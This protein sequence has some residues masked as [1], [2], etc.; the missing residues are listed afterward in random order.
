MYKIDKEINKREQSELWSEDMAK[1][2]IFERSRR[3]KKK[4]TVASSMF[5][6]LFLFF[7]ISFNVSL[8]EPEDSL[9]GED[10]IS[11]V[12]DST[13]PYSIPQYVDEFIFFSF[14]GQ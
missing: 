13:Y 4:L 14:D 9:W 8:I 10:Y 11:S 1:R 2:V 12:T 6:V 3:T 5:M 7:V